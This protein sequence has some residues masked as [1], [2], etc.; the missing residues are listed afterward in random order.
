M[1]LPEQLAR[2]TAPDAPLTQ[3][4]GAVAVTFL[5]HGILYALLTDWGC[6]FA[7]CFDTTTLFAVLQL[8]GAS[9]VPLSDVAAS[10]I[11]H[12]ASY[13]GEIAVHLAWLAPNGGLAP[14]IGAW[15]PYPFQ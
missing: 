4:A 15:D 1:Y 14:G 12:P 9:T 6:D 13:A 3:P 10:V 11:A 8:D 2:G 7:P 5:V